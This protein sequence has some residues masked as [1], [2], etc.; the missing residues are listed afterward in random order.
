[1]KTWMIDYAIRNKQTGEITEGQ[2][3]VKAFSIVQ[4]IELA[5]RNTLWNV[6]CSREVEIVI[7][8]AGIMEDEL[9]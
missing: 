9:F 8:N 7:W 1:M 4:A 6:G 5:Y 2:K 3:F